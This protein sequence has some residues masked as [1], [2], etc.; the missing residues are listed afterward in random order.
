[1]CFHIV[2]FVKPQKPVMTGDRSRMIIYLSVTNSWPSWLKTCVLSRQ[3]GERGYGVSGN[4]TLE[5][6]RLFVS[7][8][9][10]TILL[11]VR[12]FGG[13]QDHWIWMFWWSNIIS[14]GLVPP[15]HRQLWTLLLWPRAVLPVNTAI[16]PGLSQSWVSVADRL[17]G[18]FSY[19]LV[20]RCAEFISIYPEYD[21]CFTR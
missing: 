6:R 17:W 14:G 10:V 4:I 1:M 9:H 16:R 11:M 3:K 13:P 19:R 8:G 21:F 2:N 12:Y 20:P 15:D 5:W 7:L 18:K